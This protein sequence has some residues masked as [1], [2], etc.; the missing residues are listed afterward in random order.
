MGKPHRKSIIKEALDRLESKMAIGESRQEAK[1]AVRATGQPAWAFSTG[2]IHSYKTRTD[3][4]EHTLRFVNWARETYH[5]TSLEELDAQADE[6]AILYL[7]KEIAA[8]KSPY[9]LQLERSA[10]RLFFDNRTLA[11]EIA[12]PRRIRTSIT[13][14]RRPAAR[15]RYFQPAH[16][17][18][19]L[20]F[21]RAVGLRRD[22]LV[23]LT[24]ADVHHNHQ[25]QV[26]VHVRNGKGGKERDVPVLPG[27]EQDVLS[28]VAERK[29]E[30]RVFARLPDTEM[31]SYRRE[32][33]Q[34][35]YLYHAPGWELPPATG[36]L[37]R[38][39]YD[40]EAVMRV[41]RA[42]GHNRREVVLNN[43]LR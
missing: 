12:L 10:L 15:D 14:S 18:P 35:L 9:T 13:R 5:I 29:A 16:W 43:Y 22:E 40:L 4:Q 20:N 2:K 33:A 42:L 41:S 3:Y 8:Q 27:H 19:L 1:K 6:L 11:S 38:T 21:Q 34:A 31:H 36:R 24:V 28:V 7:Q 30:E 37:Q 32:Y 25:G 26:I 23:R 17:Q 39:D